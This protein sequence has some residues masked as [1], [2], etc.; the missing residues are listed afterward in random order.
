V[1]I[2]LDE[3]W[4]IVEWALI[5]P[6]TSAGSGLHRISTNLPADKYPL[7][8]SRD[9]EKMRI[10][11]YVYRRVRNQVDSMLKQDYCV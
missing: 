1:A 3:V 7:Y 5:F 10:S 2:F 6:A 8:L 9:R 11:G 4:P